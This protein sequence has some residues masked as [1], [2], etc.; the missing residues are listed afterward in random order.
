MDY[1]IIRREAFTVIGKLIEISIKDEEHH[2]AINGFWDKCNADGTCERIRSIDNSQHLLG[3]TMEFADDR[4]HFSYMIAI[5]NL[6]NYTETDFVTREIPAA[7]WAV[8]TSVGPM[9]LAIVNVMVKIYH[10]WFPKTGYEQVDAPMLEVY[11]PG[12]TSA[13]DYKC[14]IWVPVAR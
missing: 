8:F 12:D 11:F 9:P 1:K 7:N 6:N 3:I 13:L 10:E 14:E 5:E 4:E 2:R